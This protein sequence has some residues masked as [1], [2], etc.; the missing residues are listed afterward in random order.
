MKLAIMSSGDGLSI[1]TALVVIYV[2]DEYEMLEVLGFES[3]Q[4]QALMGEG[5]DRLEVKKNTFDITYLY[6]DVRRL[7]EIGFR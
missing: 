1:E 3:T 5:Y 6:F 2:P 7:F 4:K